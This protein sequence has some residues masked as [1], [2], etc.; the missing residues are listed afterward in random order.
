ML[1]RVIEAVVFDWGGT[2]TPWHDVNL[3]DSWQAFAHGYRTMACA[4]NNLTATLWQAESLA[5]Q[6][7]RADHA[8]SRI[9]Q[10]IASAGV[11]LTSAAFA[12]GMA[13]YWAFWEPHTV[14]HP[15]VYP[16]FAG[17]RERGIRI[18]VLSNTMWPRSYHHG[19]FVRDE[20]DEFLAAEV[21]TC[22]LP[23]A[24]PHPDAFATALA[25]LAVTPDKALYVG[26]RLIEDIFGAQR[27]GMRTVLLD[28]D[29]FAEHRELRHIAADH[30]ITELPALLGFIDSSSADCPQ[31]MMCRG[32]ALRRAVVVTGS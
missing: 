23:V 13:S 15:W 5:W 8:S 14:T 20:V 4:L 28:H 29:S 18:G 31:P 21:Y 2:L 1:H 16:T 6:R 11:D 9:E 27:V 3:R 32:S 24:K 10:V 12:T 19:L 26:D 7:C 30:T 17:L 22:E 25:E